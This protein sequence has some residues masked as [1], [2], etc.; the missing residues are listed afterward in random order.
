MGIL[1]FCN[2]IQNNPQ[3]ANIQRRIKI[4]GRKDVPSMSFPQNKDKAKKINLWYIRLKF[5]TRLNI[6]KNRLN[7]GRINVCKNASPQ[8]SITSITIQYMDEQ[9]LGTI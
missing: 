6:R 3:K 1:H 8:T 2:F 4:L 7:H 5:K 9:L